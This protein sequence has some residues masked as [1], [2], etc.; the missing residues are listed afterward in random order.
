MWDQVEY[1]V[2]KNIC[3]KIISQTL[4]FLSIVG[5]NTIGAPKMRNSHEPKLKVHK[6]NIYDKLEKK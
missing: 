1:D 4:N 6:K 3:Y 5:K 2:F